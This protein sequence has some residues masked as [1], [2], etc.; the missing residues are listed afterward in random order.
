MR[1][2][3]QFYNRVLEYR[4]FNSKFLNGL[5]NYALLFLIATTLA[6]APIMTQYALAAEVISTFDAK[7]KVTSSTI[8]GIPVNAQYYVS[9]IRGGWYVMDIIA[10]TSTTHADFDKNAA[11]TDN[12]NIIIMTST[13]TSSTI[14]GL[15]VGDQ[16]KCTFDNTI[17]V[18][19]CS[20][21]SKGTSSIASMWFFNPSRQTIPDADTTAPTVSITAPANG[22]TISGT[23]SVTA[24]ASDNV[25]VAKVV[26]YVDGVLKST[27]T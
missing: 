25:G 1:L 8:N 26:F 3:K 22:A 17:A 10:G 24:S 5:L 7:S 9:Y 13:V 15:A 23:V 21:L 6:I 2:Q 18:Q 16:V 19:T 4:I 11:I 14:T 12:G 27:D 20:N